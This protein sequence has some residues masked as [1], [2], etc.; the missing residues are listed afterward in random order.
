MAYITVNLR[1]RKY[2]S[3]VL[4]V[5][6]EKFGLKDKG[7]ALDKFAELYGDDFIDREVRDDVAR[8]VIR[9]VAAHYKKY[10]TK[11][12]TDEELDKLTGV[13]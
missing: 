10:G 7:Q 2:S 8:D 4:G 3:Q 11:A 6:K 13:S 5:V 9:S 12:M 1:V